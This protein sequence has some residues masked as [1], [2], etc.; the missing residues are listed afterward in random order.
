MSGGV[1]CVQ[2]L[3]FI[4]GALEV[5]LNGEE[6]KHFEEITGHYLLAIEQ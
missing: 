6:V 2:R 3:W 4:L 5:K 1:E